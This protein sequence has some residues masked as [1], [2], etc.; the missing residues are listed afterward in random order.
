MGQSEKAGFRE[1][2]HLHFCRGRSTILIP[3]GVGLWLW[4]QPDQ[5]L[6]WWANTSPVDS[7]ATEIKEEARIEPINVK[8]LTVIPGCSAGVTKIL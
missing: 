3:G 7:W 1:G 4:Q 5:N 6:R 8:V 2:Q